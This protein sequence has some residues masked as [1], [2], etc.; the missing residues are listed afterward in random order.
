MERREIK[1]FKGA[2]SNLMKISSWNVRGLGSR[3]KKGIFERAVSLLKARHRN[4]TTN[5]E[6]ITRE[7]VS[8]PAQGRSGGIVVIWN[9]KQILVIEPLVGVFSISIKIKALNGLDWWLSGE[10]EGSFGKKWQVFMGFVDQDG[11]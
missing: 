5:Q 9:T 3:Q 10:R 8:A 11:V 1:K 4:F 2:L 6:S 7:W